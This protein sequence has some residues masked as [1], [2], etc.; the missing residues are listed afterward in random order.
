MDQTLFSLLDAARQNISNDALS[1]IAD[2]LM[3]V[4]SADR[5]EVL[6]RLFDAE[7]ALLVVRS[8]DYFR[9]G[10]TMWNSFTVRNSRTLA[11]EVNVRTEQARRGLF[12]D[13]SERIESDHWYAI[14]LRDKGFRPMPWM[15]ANEHHLTLRVVPMNG[16]RVRGD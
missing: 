15:Q 7:A 13:L 16:G 10:V 1:V 9:G 5:V 12:I 8:G 3:E 11:D 14:H 4:S 2:R 6:R